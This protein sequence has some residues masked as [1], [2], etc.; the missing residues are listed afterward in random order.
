M[1]I[2]QSIFPIIFFFLSLIIGQDH[3]INFDGRIDEIRIWNVPREQDDI[4]AT[5]DTVLS[6][7]ETGLVAYYTFNE[8]SGIILYDQTDN[9]HNGTLVGGPSWASGYTLS[10]LL[11]DVN[12]DEGINIYDA[13]MLVAIMLEFED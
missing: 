7:S 3:S 9:G 6:G 13:V 2:F 8:G 1:K 4:I 11:G 12:F 10:G 5:M